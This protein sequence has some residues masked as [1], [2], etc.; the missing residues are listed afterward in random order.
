MVKSDDAN[1]PHC[2]AGV[3]SECRERHGTGVLQLSVGPCVHPRS[4]V[5]EKKHHP[6]E[7]S[8]G[9]S[10]RRVP[11]AQGLSLTGLEVLGSH[12][13]QV[14]SPPQQYTLRQLRQRSEL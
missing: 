7:G 8:L 11:K 4:W 9:R 13:E 2:R 12:A 14:L 3:K 1:S 5:L 10:R 6:K